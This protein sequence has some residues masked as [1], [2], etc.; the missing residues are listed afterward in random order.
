MRAVILV[1][2]KGARLMP[3]TTVFPKA[4]MPIGDQPVLEII[5]RQMSRYGFKRITMA[6]NRHASLIK[7]FFGSGK[8]WGVAIDYSLEKKPLGTLGPLLLVKNLP[9][10]FLVMNGDV[11]TDLNFR[12]F[13]QY[14]KSTESLLTVASTQRVISVN[15]GI[16][17][18]NGCR[19]IIGFREK[20][21]FSFEV[22]MGIY[23]LSRPVLDQIPQGE[24]CGFDQLITRLIKGNSKKK[25][26]LYQH[27]G[28][29]LDIGNPDDYARAAEEFGLKKKPHPKSRLSQGQRLSYL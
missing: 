26:D 11:L 22:S 4:L 29:W 9:D 14:H 13:M 5:V 23:A 21:V 12:K 24:A 15:S 28:Y 20:P 1:G 25:P 19:E 3:Y 27:R 16:F 7:A 17:E 10:H 6:V 18:R 8:R 2:G